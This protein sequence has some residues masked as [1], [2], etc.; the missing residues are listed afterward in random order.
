MLSRASLAERSLKQNHYEFTID[1]QRSLTI[2]SAFENGNVR[3]VKQLNELYV[4][5]A[6]DSTSWKRSTTWRA[7]RAG[8]AGSTFG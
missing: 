1:N 5:G 7:C 6:I 2:S 8:N 3:L 4:V